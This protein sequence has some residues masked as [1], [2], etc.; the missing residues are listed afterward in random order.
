MWAKYDE[1]LRNIGHDNYISIKVGR[2]KKQNKIQEKLE[3]FTCRPGY[4]FSS[5]KQ[6]VWSPWSCVS[7]FQPQSLWKGRVLLPGAHGGWGPCRL[8]CAHSLGFL[9]G[10]RHLPMCAFPPQVGTSETERVPCAGT[11]A[12]RP[13][14]SGDR[15]T[16]ACV[17]ALGSPP[18]GSRCTE[19]QRTVRWG[20]E[21][22]GCQTQTVGMEARAGSGR[23]DSHCSR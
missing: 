19:S 14:S 23:G 5:E 18:V 8:H 2:I 21:E 11:G 1:T 20:R 3:D 7:V 17:A 6:Q 12:S 16:L 10:G 22:G 13:P 9:V 4:L 15:W